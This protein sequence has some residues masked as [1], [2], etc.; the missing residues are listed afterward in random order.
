MSHG[1]LVPMNVAAANA[2]VIGQEI[3]WFQ[4]VMTRRADAARRAGAG[5]RCRDARACAGGAFRSHALRHRRPALR[6]GPCRAAA[7]HPR[8]AAARTPGRPRF[9]SH[10]ERGDCPPLHRIRRRRRPVARRLPP[11]RRDR[12]V[13]AGGQR[14]RGAASLPCALSR[15]P[16]PLSEQHPAPGAPPRRRAG[17]LRAAAA[18]GR[19]PRAPGQRPLV[20]AALQHRI[21]RRSS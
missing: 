10:P 6:H 12:D 16:L 21:S 14:Y 20:P 19:V 11:D 2:S 7:R 3:A 1:R 5:G 17:A 13:P 18:V 15:R 8:A 9:V 4:E